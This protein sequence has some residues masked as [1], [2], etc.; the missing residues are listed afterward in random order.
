MRT[1]RV[2]RVEHKDTGDGP[3]N[4]G[5]SSHYT[6]NGLHPTHS[7]S[8]DHPGVQ[9]DVWEFVSGVH[10]CGFSTLDQAHEWFKGFKQK[11]RRHGYVINVYEA[12]ATGLYLGISGKQLVFLRDDSVKVDTLPIYRYADR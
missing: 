11:L 5:D 7:N 9:V 8:D 12:P 1:K 4:S 3:Y 6:I 2:Y 10:Y